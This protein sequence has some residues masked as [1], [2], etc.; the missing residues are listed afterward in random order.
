ML[1]VILFIILGLLYWA[2]KGL[3]IKTR[4]VRIGF[5]L[6]TSMLMAVLFW[7]AL[8]FHMVTASVLI[9]Y[10][11]ISYVEYMLTCFNI[12]VPIMPVYSY[13][14]VISKD[15]AIDEYSANRLW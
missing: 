11:L 13:V 6:A 8:S 12:R 4:G 2:V 3:V 7:L 15:V 9:I 5:M 1:E 10:L 14:R